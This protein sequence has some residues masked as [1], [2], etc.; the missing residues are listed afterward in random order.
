MHSEKTLRTAFLP[1]EQFVADDM[2]DN[3]VHHTTP[4]FPQPPPGASL[5]QRIHH[6]ELISLHNSR[7]QDAKSPHVLR[8][9]IMCALIL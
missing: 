6:P 9:D 8:F 2:V 1:R 5:R 4:A 3:C 7:V